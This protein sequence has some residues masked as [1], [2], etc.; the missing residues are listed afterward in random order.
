MLVGRVERRQERVK[1]ILFDGLN[2][3]ERIIM[4]GYPAEDEIY[5]TVTSAGKTC[6]PLL[7][8][9]IYPTTAPIFVDVLLKAR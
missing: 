9:R 3:D 2:E 8:Y 7:L 4:S 6:V 1:R 5:E